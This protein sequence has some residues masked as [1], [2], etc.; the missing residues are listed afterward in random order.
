MNRRTVLAA[1]GSILAA[2]CSQNRGGGGNGVYQDIGLDNISNTRTKFEFGGENHSFDFDEMD[3]PEFDFN[4]SQ[5]G[6]DVTFDFGGDQSANSDSLPT[7]A[8]TNRQATEY[9]AQARQ[10][11]IEAIKIYAGFGGERVDIT[12]VTPT[13]ESFSQYRVKSKIDNTKQPLRRAT[14]YATE[15]QKVYIL[16][17]EQTAIFLKHVTEAEAELQTALSEYQTSMN[18]LYNADTTNFEAPQRRLQDHITHARGET[19]L[20]RSETDASALQVIDSEGENLYE[21]KLAQFDSLIQTFRSLDEGI[22]EIGDGLSRLK[23]GVE[24]Y[25][26]RE[27][28][29]ASFPLTT[30]TG[31]LSSGRSAFESARSNGVLQSTIEPGLDFARVLYQISED[32]SQSTEA[33]INDNDEKYVNYREKA[34]GHLRANNQTRY[35]SEINQIQ[36]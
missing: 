24:S 29:D 14:E 2:G 3:K 6:S 8:E 7:P 22:T 5:L 1:I 9:I 13:T 32:L 17:L 25:T 23:E 34:I 36:W 21:A 31:D 15:G 27:Y 26:T 4:N 10:K 16:A 35:M 12:S 30:A 18:F 11:L 20:I 28:E 19:D 33:K